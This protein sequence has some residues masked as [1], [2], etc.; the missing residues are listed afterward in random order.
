MKHEPYL[1][2][3]EAA[4][5]SLMCRMKEVQKKSKAKRV[6]INK[7][8]SPIEKYQNRHRIPPEIKAE[9][10][11]NSGLL[12][13]IAQTLDSDVR[14]SLPVCFPKAFDKLDPEISFAPEGRVL[15]SERSPAHKPVCKMTTVQ[16]P[17]IRGG[18]GR[19]FMSYEDRHSI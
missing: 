6:Q 5:Y 2:P 15:K 18:R 17:S 14:K 9:L 1:V 13:K 4:L 7:P 11:E 19:M 16:Q 3:T 8:P 12:P 10:D